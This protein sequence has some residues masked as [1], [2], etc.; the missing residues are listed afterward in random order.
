MLGTPRRRAKTA[1]GPH[2]SDALGVLEQALMWL[3]PIGSPN[4]LRS[5]AQMARGFPK[6]AHMSISFSE[7][8]QTVLDAAPALSDEKRETITT[9]IAGGEK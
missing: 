8:V 3:A 1:Q 5:T 6:G 7:Y 2:E 9:L 4:H